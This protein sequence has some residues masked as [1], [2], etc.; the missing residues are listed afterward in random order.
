MQEIS[1][2][3]VLPEK[4]FII[5]FKDGSY[6]EIFADNETEAKYT[7]LDMYP[8]INK[9]EIQNITESIHFTNLKK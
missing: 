5:Y 6:K 8:Y 2:H 7:L 3:D 9:N 1:L 4:V